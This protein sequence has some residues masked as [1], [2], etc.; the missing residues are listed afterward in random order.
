MT[1]DAV[2]RPL[3]GYI[4]FPSGEA[5]LSTQTVLEGPTYGARHLPLTKRTKAKGTDVRTSAAA[6]D[7]YS[8]LSEKE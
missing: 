6:K 1:G 2:I 8:T 4:P 3:L 7:A 5:K